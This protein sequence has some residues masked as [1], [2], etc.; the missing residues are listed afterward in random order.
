MGN[1][2]ETQK[3]HEKSNKFQYVN[4]KEKN[5]KVLFISLQ[6]FINRYS[7]N[8]KV[9]RNHKI[10]FMISISSLEKF[11]IFCFGPQIIVV[12]SGLFVIL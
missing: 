3:K 2:S 9:K 8:I 7:F 11:I 6:K 1:D 5:P 12:S 10:Y 4:A